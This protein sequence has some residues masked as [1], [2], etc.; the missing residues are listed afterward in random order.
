MPN[1]VFTTGLLWTVAL[2][3]LPAPQ[4]AHPHLLVTWSSH[5]AVA[6][7]TLLA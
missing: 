7:P 5:L 6:R 4:T 3:A 2:Q 1:A